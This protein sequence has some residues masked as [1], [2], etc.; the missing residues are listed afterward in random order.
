M[1]ALGYL[2]VS[3]GAKDLTPL[4]NSVGEH[5]EDRLGVL[6]VDAGVGDADAVLEGRL[7]LGGDFLVAFLSR[8]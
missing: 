3:V 6:P 7:A 4:L 2:S 1:L 8:C 5:V